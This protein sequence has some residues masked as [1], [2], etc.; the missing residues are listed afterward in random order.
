M[1]LVM[2]VLALGCLSLAAYLVY[3]GTRPG[4]S[5]AQTP[6]SGDGI[7]AA[8]KFE[9]AATMIQ[10]KRIDVN[11]TWSAPNGPLFLDR[12]KVQFLTGNLEVAREIDFDVGQSIKSYEFNRRFP[13]QPEAKFFGLCFVYGPKKTEATQMTGVLYLNRADGAES[14]MLAA[15]AQDIPSAPGSCFK[16]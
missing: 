5:T 3:K 11:G 14:P 13:L 8:A 10:G 4:V 1:R 16:P 9:G 2:I 7:P 15:P 12:V 6:G